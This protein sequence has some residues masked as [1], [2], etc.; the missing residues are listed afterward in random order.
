MYLDSCAA[1]FAGRNKYLLGE[2]ERAIAA[3]GRCWKR[4]GRYRVHGGVTAKK[5]QARTDA[6]YQS[7]SSNCKK[8]FF[9]KSVVLYIKQWA[10]SEWAVGK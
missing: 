7:Q 4:A 8:V 10:V 5:K 6:Q 1:L 3:D 2:R 9:A